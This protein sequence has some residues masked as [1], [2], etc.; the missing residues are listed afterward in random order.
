MI[1]LDLT[2]EHLFDEHSLLAGAFIRCCG[3]RRGQ[4][5]GPAR[6]SCRYGSVQQKMEVMYVL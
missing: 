4:R 2:R 6:V 1:E 3:P 5:W